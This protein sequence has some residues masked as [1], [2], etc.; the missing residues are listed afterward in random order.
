LKIKKTHALSG[1]IG[2]FGVGL[3]DALATFT[4][5]RIGVIIQSSFGTFR[6][7]QV[8]KHGI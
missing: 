1:I 8:H 7:K 4:V 2:K 5:G 6:L 3:K